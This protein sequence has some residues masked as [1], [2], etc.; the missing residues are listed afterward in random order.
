MGCGCK[1]QVSN[2]QKQKVI[3]QTTSRNTS[4]HRR[5]IKRPAFYK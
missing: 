1:K 2:I 4:S 3:K 5:I